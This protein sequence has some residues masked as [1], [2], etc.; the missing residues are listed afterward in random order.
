MQIYDRF[1]F[2]TLYDKS[3]DSIFQ[4]NPSI[5]AALMTGGANLAGLPQH[6]QEKVNLLRQVLSL[7]EES[8]SMLP[9]DEQRSIRILKENLRRR[10]N[11]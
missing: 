11:F 2:V 9:E 6:E 8:I 3:T 10:G 7:S 4:L 5:A 1:N